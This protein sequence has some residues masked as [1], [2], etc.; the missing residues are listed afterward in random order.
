MR[1]NAS[2]TL[3]AMEA[4]VFL[5]LLCLTPLAY[6]Q[7][8][9]PP[10]SGGEPFWPFPGSPLGLSLLA[11]GMRPPLQYETSIAHTRPELANKNLPVGPEYLREG[12]ALGNEGVVEDGRYPLPFGTKGEKVGLVFLSGDYLP[13]EGE[14]LQPALAQLARKRAG[15]LSAQGTGI[16]PSV[17]ALILLNGRLDDGLQTWLQERGVQ[18]LGFYPYTAYQARIPVSQ[19][20]AV[21]SHPQVRWVG[22]P[23]PLQKLDPE[24]RMFM[25]DT[26]G[27]RIWLFVNL[28]GHDESAREAIA[29]MVESTGTY[30][31]SLGVLPIV[32]DAATVNRLLDMDAV[33]FVEPIRQSVAHHT[34]SQASINAD[35][36]WYYQHDGRPEGGRSIKVGEMDSGFNIYHW[37]FTNIIGG[38]AGYNRTTETNLWDDQHGHGT[39]VLGTFIGEGVAQARYRGTAQGVQDTNVDGFDLLVS[40][41]FRGNGKSEGSSVWEGLLDMQG[42]E[43]RYRRQ[44]FN[45]SGGASGTNL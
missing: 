8:P 31:P 18:L 43:L 36:L 24:L 40:K 25:G 17:Y 34:Q 41:V 22:Q 29:G 1:T 39:H 4:T 3:P 10:A 14:K 9:K 44:V 26:S 11:P 45:Y 38:T 23:Y 28:F 7:P 2:K 35:L 30:D 21:A 15:Q 37:D 33:L 5:L 19:L 32:T 27:E 42:R 12:L 16:Q 20:N 6:A 13:P